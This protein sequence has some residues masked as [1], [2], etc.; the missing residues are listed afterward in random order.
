MTAEYQSKLQEYEANV[1]SLSDLLKQTKAKEITDLQQRIQN[2]QVQAQDELQKK[3]AELLQPIIDKA[4]VAIK[5]VAEKNGYSYVFDSSLG[6][7]IHSPS[8]D[9]ILPLVKKQLGIE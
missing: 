7:L 9:D 3:E 2:F 1:A 6:V 8:G 5:A 4:K